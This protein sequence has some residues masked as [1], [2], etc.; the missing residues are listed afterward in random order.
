MKHYFSSFIT[1][2]LVSSCVKDKPQEPISSA[3]SI[4]ADAKVLVINEGN[5]GWNAGNGNSSISIY[6]P[7]SGAVIEDYYKQ[8]NPSK[9]L[10]D[11]CQSITKYNGNYYIV[12]NNS[13]KI[14]VVDA[15]D[16]K[17]KATISGL[18][19][20]RYFS[21]IT[22][23]KAY[24]SDLNQNSISII[25]LNTNAITG[26]IPCMKGTEQ[27]VVIYNKA[28]VTNGNS[29]Y[30][31]VINTTTDA[32]TDSINIGKGVSSIIIDKN[33]AVWILAGG[34]SSNNQAGKLHK[35]NPISLQIKQTLNFTSSDSPSHL[36][37]NKTHDTLYYI[38]SDVFQMPITTT[39]LPSNPIIQHGTKV[40]YGLGINSKDYHIYVSDA[41]DYV[42]KSTIEIYTVNGGLITKFN[43]GHISNG[44]M[45]E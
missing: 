42:Q 10:G 6:D 21:P 14:E 33:S 31:Y 15:Y 11:V 45:F 25:N 8:Q 39:Q 9:N 34:S 43:A 1:I 32:I 44:F 26:S 17:N 16:F 4:N 28:F 37:V 2:L 24:V 41:I 36:C 7:T 40:F 22:Y 12:V 35:I 5:F 13:H 18:N 29:D 20:P 3:V 38:N 27:M 30:C 19:S 23:N